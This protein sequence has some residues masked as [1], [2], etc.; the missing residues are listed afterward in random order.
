MLNLKKRIAE[1][2]ATTLASMTTAATPD[3]DELAT[4]LEYP[5]DSTMGDLALPCFRFA[6]VMRKAPKMIAEAIAA[7]FTCDGIASV[8]AINGYLNFKISPDFF[9]KTVLPEILE[10]G[11]D[12]GKL[13]VGEGNESPM[14]LPHRVFN[15]DSDMVLIA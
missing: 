11:A 10:K 4:L 3:A 8:S 5:P 15:A 9:G 13:N 7:S 2:L 1:T 14:M 12:Y 6:K